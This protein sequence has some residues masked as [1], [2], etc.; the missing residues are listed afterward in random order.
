MN[1]VSGWSVTVPQY[2]FELE[3]HTAYFCNSPVDLAHWKQ[4]YGK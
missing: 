3:C 4:N 1:V 2:H